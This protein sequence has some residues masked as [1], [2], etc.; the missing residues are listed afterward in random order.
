[1]ASDPQMNAIF[2]ANGYGIKSGVVLDEI[3]NLSIAPTLAELLGVQ[4]PKTKAKALSE[5]LTMGR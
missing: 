1:L 5:I 4:F 3:Q 2:V